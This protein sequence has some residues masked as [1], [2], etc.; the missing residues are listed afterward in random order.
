MDYAGLVVNFKVNRELTDFEIKNHLYQ[1]KGLNIYPHY[2]LSVIKM[3][4]TY[5]ELVDKWYGNKGFMSFVSIAFLALFIGL[6]LPLGIE[7]TLTGLGYISTTSEEEHI[8]GYGI[9]ILTILAPAIWI[10]L[11]LLKKE[12]FAFTH[13]PTI[14]NRK[15]RMVHV[16]NVD[17][18]TFSVP[19]DETYFTLSQVDSANKFCNIVGHVLSED[20]SKI[21]NT[22]SLSV[23]QTDSEEGLHLL[24]RHWEFVRRYMELGPDSVSPQIQFCLPINK[25]R[26]TL[27]FGVHRLLANSST[28]E[29]LGWPIFLISIGLDL[30][31]VPFR[32]VAIQTS[33]IP[34]WPNSI[35]AACEIQIND[36]Y[37]FEGN[38][39]GDRS[40]VYPDAAN[41]AGISFKAPPV[42]K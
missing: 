14:F 15:T 17:G 30:I 22:F 26:E 35:L 27:K 32:Y 2:Q 11:W 3:N 34:T 21:L 41:A 42:T 7:V 37:A 6:L 8:L 29:P 31:T 39:E 24:R 38:P 4:S 5:L 1:K 10:F 33:Q 28:D 13:Y 12:C 9:F 18:S 23:S 19:W 36:P 16:F 40:A 20:N 25:K